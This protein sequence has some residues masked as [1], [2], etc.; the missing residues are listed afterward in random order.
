[1][2]FNFITPKHGSYG[3]KCSSITSWF[4]QRS[5]EWV[6]VELEPWAPPRTW[7]WKMEQEG[8]MRILVSWWEKN[9]EEHEKCLANSL[10]PLQFLQK[11]NNG[12]SCLYFC[13]FQLLGRALLLLSYTLI[14]IALCAF[15]V[16]LGDLL[17]LFFFTHLW[18][19]LF[20]F[21]FH[22]YPTS[23]MCC[24]HCSSL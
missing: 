15:L 19:I 21:S 5:K 2:K 24:F 4:T 3:I 14:L 10:K 7:T 9:E 6:W 16:K 8:K 13:S 17:S 22:C 23:C 12:E 1:M 11:H 20:S 18:W